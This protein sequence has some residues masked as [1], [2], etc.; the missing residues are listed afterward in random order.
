MKAKDRVALVLPCNSTGSHKIPVAV[1][2]AAAVPLCFKAPRSGCLLPY[3]SQT[4]AWLDGEVYKKWFH[5]VFLRDARERTRSRVNIVVATCGAHNALECESIKFCSLPPSLTS[6]HQPLDEGIITYPKRRYEK[7]QISIVLRGLDENQ[8]RQ[9][10]AVVTAAEAATETAEAVP[11]AETKRPV[12]TLS[13][14]TSS[15]AMPASEDMGAGRAPA[16]ERGAPSSTGPCGAPVGV[17]PTARIPEDVLEPGSAPAALGTAA[18]TATHEGQLLPVLP[19]SGVR[20]RVQPSKMTG[21]VFEGDST[22]G[23]TPTGAARSLLAVGVRFS[24]VRFD[25]SLGQPLELPA[26]L[27]LAQQSGA[28]QPTTCAVDAVAPPSNRLIVVPG[29]GLAITFPRTGP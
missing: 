16:A 28:S 4:S 29:T 3:F 27:P 13:S 19:F 12:T 15:S 26:A 10:A 5:K 20:F 9:E 25:V 14:I 23:L 17:V 24:G 7:R 6:A 2:G 18:P 22:I 11:P 1:I 8:Y 21:I